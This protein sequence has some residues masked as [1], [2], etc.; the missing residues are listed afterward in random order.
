MESESEDFEKFKKRAKWLS[1]GLANRENGKLPRNLC[2]S[3]AHS[4][5][6]LIRGF[7]RGFLVASG[8]LGGVKLL[9]TFIRTKSFSKALNKALEADTRRF[10][11][12]LGAFLGVFRYLNSLFA[13]IRGKDG[14]ENALLAGFIAGYTCLLDSKSRRRSLSIILFVRAIEISL[15]RLN[16]LKELPDIPQPYCGALS[17]GLSNIFIMY[18]TLYEPTLLDPSYYYWILNMSGIPDDVIKSIGRDTRDA[19]IYRGNILPFRTCDKGY[20]EGPC[21]LYNIKYF[22]S[23]LFTSAKIYIPVH[24]I[25]ILLFK[26]NKMT[27]N[28]KEGILQVFKSYIRNVIQSV[29]FLS[30]YILIMKSN[31]CFW[32]NLFEA[33]KPW[34]GSFA[35]FCTGLACL[36]ERNSRVNDLALFC[37]PKSLEIA[38]GWLYKRGIVNG[39]KNGEVHMFSASIA[40]LL[41]SRQVDYKQTYFN[42]AKL[43]IGSPKVTKKY[44]K[45]K[46]QL[47]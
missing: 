6:E 45:T 28:N 24:L 9:T 47:Q 30:T 23:S 7:S 37:W 46:K 36:F 2:L 12:F 44:K 41:A 42:I 22:Y 26:L 17:F 11:I 13:F 27:I 38:W 25:P 43:V 15:Q 20:H 19:R 21:S 14:Q 5:R 3:F 35:G 10:A 18:A 8:L 16:R 1:K 32:R 34:M 33:D 29:L 4:R 31:L 40:I 39:I